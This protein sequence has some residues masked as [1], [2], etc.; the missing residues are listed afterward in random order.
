MYHA[1]DGASNKGDCDG[2]CYGT[3]TLAGA[4]DEHRYI[5]ERERLGGDEAWIQGDHKG[6]SELVG[7]QMG[8]CVRRGGPTQI[9]LA[10]AYGC[11]SQI[12]W[13]SRRL[14]VSSTND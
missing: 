14:G 10:T 5:G 7:T 12:C 13:D 4:V 9:D 6:A 11:P 3:R 8:Q 2:S 1:V